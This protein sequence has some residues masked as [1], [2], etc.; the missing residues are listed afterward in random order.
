MKQYFTTVVLI[1]MIFKAVAQDKPAYVIFNSEGK[2]VDYSDMVKKCSK[3]DMIFFGELHNNPISHWLQLELT[4]DL[5]TDK[6]DKL[7]LG[8][9]MFESDNQLVLNEYLNGSISTKSFEAECKLWDN[10]VTDYKPI[11]EFAKLK[12]IPVIASNVPRRYAAM[13]HGKGFDVLDSLP[14]ESKALFFNDMKKIYDENVGCY[15]SMMDMKEM[16]GHV[17]ANFPKAQ[18]LKDATMAYFILKYYKKDYTLIHYQGAY[19]SDNNEGILWWIGKL[20]GNVK[21]ATISTKE[22]KNIDKLD[23]ENK[24]KA[25]FIIV[26]PETMTKTK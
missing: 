6:Q 26:T 11:I 3:A 7:I 21:M 5:Y 22:Q 1:F 19:H 2:K 4:K 12:K 8:A 20:S 10:Y 9:E 24:L 16:G 25:D 23:D 18:A 13:V 14:S 17:N 15:K